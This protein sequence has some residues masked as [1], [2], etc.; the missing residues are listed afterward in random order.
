[1]LLFVLES[2]AFHLPSQRSGYFIWN[3]PTKIPPQIPIKNPLQI[4]RNW[5]LQFIRKFLRGRSLHLRIPHPP[6]ASPSTPLCASHRVPSLKFPSTSVL[7]KENSILHRRES[8]QVSM[9]HPTNAKKSVAIAFI[10]LLNV[11]LLLVHDPR[12]SEN[13]LEQTRNLT[14]RS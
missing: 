8:V 7:L 2:Y 4:A 11:H 5:S 1:M 9:T 13:D 14:R 6:L 3:R 10:P 12:R